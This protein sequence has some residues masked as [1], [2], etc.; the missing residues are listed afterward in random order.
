MFT[1][2]L[3]WVQ[4]LKK[5]YS[6]N[7]LEMDP[8]RTTNISSSGFIT[9]I[10]LHLPVPRKNFPEPPGKSWSLIQNTTTG[11]DLPSKGNLRVITPPMP[12]KT[13]RNNRPYLGIIYHHDPLIRPY[14]WDSS[15]SFFN[16]KQHRS[17]KNFR[18]PTHGEKDAKKGPKKGLWCRSS[19]WMNGWNQIS[20]VKW[21]LLDRTSTTNSLL[22]L[23][24]Q[25]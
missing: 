1:S 12:R 5:I 10:Q 23:H 11:V 9:K 21:I 3:L 16:K 7:L 15:D 18:S 22:S 19:I 6:N 4:Q 8:W 24:C 2:R 20:H 17:I 13:P 25:G 14:V